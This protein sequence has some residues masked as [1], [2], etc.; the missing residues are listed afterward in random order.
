MIAKVRHFLARYYRFICVVTYRGR[1]KIPSGQRQYVYHVWCVPLAQKASARIW[2]VVVYQDRIGFYNVFC[3]ILLQSAWV[4]FDVSLWSQRVN[5][6]NPSKILLWPDTY[7][8]NIAFSVLGYEDIQTWPLHAE[9]QIFSFWEP[10]SHH[11]SLS[12]LSNQHTLSKVRKNCHPTKIWS[13]KT[14]DRANLRVTFHMGFY[15]LLIHYH[16]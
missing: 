9:C 13:S 12:Y 7:Q 8:D 3:R 4:L 6:K 15:S 10:W 2:E 5:L 14:M 1:V 16:R 11:R